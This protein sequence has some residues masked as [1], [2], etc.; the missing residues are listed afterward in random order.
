MH[1]QKVVTYHFNIDDHV[2][3]KLDHSPYLTSV[4]LLEGQRDGRLDGFLV[5]P[6]VGPGVG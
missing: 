1:K 3:D 4:G 6:K 2:Y 5:G